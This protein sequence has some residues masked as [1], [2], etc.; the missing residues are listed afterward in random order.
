MLIKLN[1][2]PLIHPKH[3]NTQNRQDASSPVAFL[4]S[5]ELGNNEQP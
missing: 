2:V 4:F 1:D 3:H 5:L